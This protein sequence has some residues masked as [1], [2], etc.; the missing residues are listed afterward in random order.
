MTGN[1]VV[2]FVDEEIRFNEQ[3]S[4]V[5]NY[6]W[7]YVRALLS[8]GLAVR[9]AR[10]PEEAFDILGTTDVDVA[11]VDL[12]M[13]HGGY[14]GKM[15]EDTFTGVAV[16]EELLSNYP[17]IPVVVFSNSTLASDAVKDLDVRCVLRKLDCDPFSFAEEIKRILS[18]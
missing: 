15:N 6:M 16:I 8:E 3:S 4:P 14:F 9:P 12:V 5:G 10:S 1:S 17:L 2:L 11:I 18:E 7:Y 13:P